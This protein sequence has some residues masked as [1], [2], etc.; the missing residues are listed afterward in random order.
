MNKNIDKILKIWHNHFKNEDNQYIEFEPSDIEYF[1]GCML[2]NH[3]AF[4]YALD[5]MK[6]MDLSYDFLENCGEYEYK[7]VKKLINSIDIKDE[8]QKI[9]FLLDFIKEARKKYTD[10]ELYLLNRL[11]YHIDSLYE[12]YKDGI[13]AQK[14][15]FEPVA[16][17]K[18]PLL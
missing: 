12:R 16:R 18:N 5:S 9:N 17:N 6:S 13:K 3:F 1:V 8:E 14:V 10:D 2:Y 11:Q 4:E 7:E 15:V